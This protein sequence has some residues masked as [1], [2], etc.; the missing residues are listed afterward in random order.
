MCLP[1]DGRGTNQGRCVKQQKRF[2]GKLAEQRLLHRCGHYEEVFRRHEKSEYG[3]V[4][5]MITKHEN[6]R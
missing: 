5:D 6:L 2:V 1:S 4:H 3:I